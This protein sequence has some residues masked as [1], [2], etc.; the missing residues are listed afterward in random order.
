MHIYNF[1]LREIAYHSLLSN[2][3]RAVRAIF[4]TLD[5]DYRMSKKINCK[6]EKTRIRSQWQEFHDVRLSHP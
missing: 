3:F 2:K 5:G 1:A 4:I 6:K